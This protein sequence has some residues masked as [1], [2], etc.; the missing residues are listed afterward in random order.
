M[1]ISLFTVLKIGLG[2][3][4]GIGVSGTGCAPIGLPV[5]PAPP[6]GSSGSVQWGE[7][8]VENFDSLSS[9]WYVYN[10]PTSRPRRSSALVSVSGGSLKLGGATDS[11]GLDF[12]SGVS[13]NAFHQKYGRWEARFRVTP[14]AGFG[15]AILLWPENGNWPRDGEVDMIEI[16]SADRHSA[17]QSIHN[18]PS[19]LQ[20]THGANNDY[21]GWHTVAVDWLPS[22]LTYYV[23]GAATWKVT[24]P[25]YIPSTGPLH[26]TLQLDEC[27]PGTYG[28]FIPCRESGPSE[29]VTLEVDWVKVYPPPPGL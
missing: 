7:P 3:A 13:D 20:A 28:G 6:A 18:G 1:K 17:I 16:P 26:L 23:D 11:A 12:G 8:T 24:G 21:T 14:G 22:G 29:G 27:S 19:N 25:A 15:V 9:R 2:I 10:F 4:A 5:T